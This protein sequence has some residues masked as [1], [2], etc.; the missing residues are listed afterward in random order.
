M[1]V[2]ISYTHDGKNYADKVKKDLRDQNIGIRIDKKCIGPGQIGLK[3]IDDALYHVDYVLGVITKDYLTSIGGAEAY[4]KIS[5]GL[6]KKD[7]RF[8]PLFF[9][10]PK[11]V[12]S[13]II[14]AIQGY[15]FSEDYE[16]GLHDLIKFRIY[17]PFIT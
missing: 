17:S 14:P 3:E 11:K 15:I 5:E 4:A 16:K 12:E 6:P 9:I 10:P 2:F 7:I 13:V 8:I 1:K